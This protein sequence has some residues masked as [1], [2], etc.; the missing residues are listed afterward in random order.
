MNVLK[1]PTEDFCPSVCFDAYFLRKVKTFIHVARTNNIDVKYSLD[2][3]EILS[4]FI[5]KMEYSQD[6]IP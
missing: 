4:K 5:S 2:L 3:Q 1:Y 6:K